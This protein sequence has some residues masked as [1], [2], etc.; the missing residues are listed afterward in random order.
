MVKNFL[1]DP[2]CSNPRAETRSPISFSEGADPRHG[3][4]AD[5]PKLNTIDT[6]Q[7]RPEI[8]GLRA[9]AVLS[10]VLCHLKIVSFE[11]GFVGVDIFFVISGYLISRNIVLDLQHKH[12]SFFDFY[13]RRV[14]RILPALI[15]TVVLTY[16]AG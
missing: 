10:V 2:M 6:G 1:T 4:D 15:F 13:M 5:V 8:S 12:F 9:I 3:I 11:G 14:R 7:F 16:I